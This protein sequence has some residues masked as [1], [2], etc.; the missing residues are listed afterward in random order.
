MGK[1]RLRWVV[2]ELSIDFLVRGPFTFAGAVP[3]CDV[4]VGVA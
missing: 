3:E 1:Y 4:A 2:V